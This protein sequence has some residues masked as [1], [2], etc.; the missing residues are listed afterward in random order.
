MNSP[1][2]HRETA[3]GL[4][5]PPSSSSG[6]ESDGADGVPGSS[7]AG[8]QALASASQPVSRE[9]EMED[10]SRTLVLSSALAKIIGKRGPGRPPSNK[11]AKGTAPKVPRRCEEDH[12]ADLR[13]RLND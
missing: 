2:W 9:V 1:R 3:R 11:S 8:S 7:G 13:A 6:G 4:S 5:N 12:P 10:S